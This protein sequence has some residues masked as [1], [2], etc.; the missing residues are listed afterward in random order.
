MKIKRTCSICGEKHFAKG[1]CDKHYKAARYAANPEK[2]KADVYAR[3]AADPEKARQC[4]SASYYF[5]RE[6]RIAH[7]KAYDLLHPQEK[8]D[9]HSEWVKANRPKVRDYHREYQRE[10]RAADP[11]RERERG[12]KWRKNNL[13]KDCAK[14]ARRKASKLQ[15]TP[16]WAND[17]FIKEI[18]H[19]AK[20]RTKIM[21]FKWEVDHIVPLRSKLVCGLHVENNLQVIPESKNRSKSNHYWP[22]MP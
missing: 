11:E 6:E 19:L 21:G 9:R 20:I 7:Q 1:L 16:K 18:Y 15:A 14:V 8:K 10:Y 2:H 12:R 17:F 5:H 13:D 4:N 3:R 22:D